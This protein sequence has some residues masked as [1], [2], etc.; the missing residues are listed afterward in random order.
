LATPDDHCYSFFFSYS[1]IYFIAPQRVN[2]L[3][4]MACWLWPGDLATLSAK[5]RLPLAKQVIGGPVGQGSHSNPV[6][7]ISVAAQNA[8]PTLRDSFTRLTLYSTVL[9]CNRGRSSGIL[10]TYSHIQSQI[11]HR[12]AISTV[13]QHYTTQLCG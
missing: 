11:A 4:G 7:E 1:Q 5:Y 6:V 12:V 8:A 10:I 2:L 9:Y 13:R 3:F